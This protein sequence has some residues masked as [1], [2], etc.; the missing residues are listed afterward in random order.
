MRIAVIGIDLGK[1]SCSL[2]A[3]DDRGA[4]VKRRRLRPDSVLT[5]TR[6]LAP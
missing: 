3:L 4:V 1:N 2:A 5:F 6:D